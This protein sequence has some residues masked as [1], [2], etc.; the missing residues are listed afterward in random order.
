MRNTQSQSTGELT[1]LL[2]GS[3]GPVRMLYRPITSEQNRNG[4]PQE[5]HAPRHT[6]ELNSALTRRNRGLHLP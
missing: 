3:R 6:A 1:R 2:T 5:K 4:E